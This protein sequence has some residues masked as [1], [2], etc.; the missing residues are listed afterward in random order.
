MTKQ[1]LLSGI[2]PTGKMHFGNYLGAI[3]NWVTLQHDY[4][5]Y[6]MMADLHALTSV[7][8]NPQK[9]RE[10]KLNLAIDIY[11]AAINPDQA[12]LYYQSDVPEHAELHLILSMM[13]PLPWLERV[14]TYKSKMA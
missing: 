6:F 14:P 7:Y 3:S 1:T 10:D 9:L 11:S 8:E 2:Q 13:T 5:A 12:C 4:N